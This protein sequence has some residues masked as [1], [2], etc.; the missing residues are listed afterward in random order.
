[1]T[2]LRTTLAWLAWKTPRF[3]GRDRLLRPCFRLL[4]R[5]RPFRVRRGGVAY[6]LGGEDINEFAIAVHD[7]HSDGVVAALT[8]AL[9]QDAAVCWDIGANIGGTALPVL[10]RCP[11]A[12][13]VAFEPG[14]QNGWKLFRNAAANPALAARLRIVAA[15]L[16]DHSELGAFGISNEPANSGVGGLGTS[17]NRCDMTIAVP[18]FA[19][20]ALLPALPAPDVVKIDVEGHELEVIRGLLALPH[21]PRAIVFEHCVYRFAER[22]MA[23]DAVVTLLRGHGYEVSALDGGPVG[24]LD[25]D[26]DLMASAGRPPR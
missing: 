6:V 13:V 11:R 16:S 21:P 10:A 25:H 20:A 26:Q 12:T 17:R 3:R 2:L 18:V 19:P 1:M 7:S 24:S 9:G 5:D 4:G 23:L 15:A 22:G 14:P 8:R